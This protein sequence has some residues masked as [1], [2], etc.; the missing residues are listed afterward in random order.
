MTDQIYR[1]Q[2]MEIFKSNANFGQMDAPTV[3]A[4]QINSICGDKIILQLKIMDDKVVDAKFTGV[5][6]AVSK[7]SAS[8]IT[9]EIKGK[10]VDDLKKL[11]EQNMLDLI[12]FD[13]TS[14]R[15]QCALLCYRALKKA[16][17]NYDEKK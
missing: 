2:F 4:D 7:T 6:C 9:E 1:E 15:Q 16:L 14:A 3:T 17:E 11:T 8:I 12:K 13:L 10:S 5:A